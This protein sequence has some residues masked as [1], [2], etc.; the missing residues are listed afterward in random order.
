LIQLHTVSIKEVNYFFPLYLYN[1]PIN[2]DTQLLG[3]GQ[4]GR[5]ANLAPG[6]VARLGGVLGLQWVSDGR[7]DGRSTL[8]PE[9][10]LAYIYAIFHAPSY[11]SRYAEFLKIDFPR[12]PLTDDAALFWELVERG[13]ELIGLHL[14]D[15]TGMARQ[16]PTNDATSDDA[17]IA[18]ILDEA[19]KEWDAAPDAAANAAME[20]LITSTSTPAG[21]VAPGHPKYVD[22]KVVINKAGEGFAD[23]PEEVWN[24]HIGGYQ[25]A[26]KWLKDRKG[27]TLSDEDAAHYRKVLLA[28]AATIKEMAAIDEIIKTHGDASQSGWPLHGSQDKST[29]SEENV[30]AFF[31]KS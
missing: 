4:N 7:G 16:A 30:K 9:D 10:V 14:L 31:K 28:L 26:H 18:A 20:R 19:E 5:R 1:P 2:W 17:D 13:R 21:E 23:V 27:R 25:V 3:T 6:F 8:G 24:F 12:V 22:G 11:R 29:F 15:D